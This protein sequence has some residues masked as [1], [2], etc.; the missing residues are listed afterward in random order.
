[1]A[2]R[3]LTET[4]VVI[5]GHATGVSRFPTTP[6]LPIEA[7]SSFRT[8][9]FRALYLQ[10]LS[11]GHLLI[12]RQTSLWR[13]MS[14]VVAA[15]ARA[16]FWPFILLYRRQGYYWV[17]LAELHD[18]YMDEAI[19]PWVNEMARVVRENTNPRRIATTVNVDMESRHGQVERL[20]ALRCNVFAVLAVL[21]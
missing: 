5:H 14:L 9:K 19:V 11:E 4:A 21:L 12:R 1:M 3:G 13:K 17:S 8:T 16:L 10:P 20:L 7:L 2:S 6:A 15:L 18:T